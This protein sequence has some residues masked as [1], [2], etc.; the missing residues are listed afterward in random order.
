[1]RAFAR[2]GSSRPG[3][4]GAAFTLVELLAVMLI[5][6][7]LVGLVVGVT[8]Y[9]MAR[10]DRIRTIAVMDVVL[11]AIQ[12]YYDDT[13][14]YPASLL[15]LVTNEAAKKL[16]V[17][18]DSETFVKDDPATNENESASIKDAYGNGIDYDEGGGL[19]GCPVLISAGPDGNFG[20][21]DDIRSDK[22][23]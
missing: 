1:M 21:K 7:I 12:A 16:L 8:R 23:R 17:N 20:N 3:R 14:E 19:G 6:A 15:S 2:S 18:L 11:D 9:A 4:S 13:K 5:L 10:A 22:R